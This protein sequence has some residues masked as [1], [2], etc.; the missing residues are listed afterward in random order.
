MYRKNPYNILLKIKNL[1]KWDK[2]SDF[3]K[4]NIGK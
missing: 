3:E 1:K 4:N 2:I